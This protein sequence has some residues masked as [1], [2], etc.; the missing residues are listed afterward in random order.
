LFNTLRDWRAERCK[1]DGVPPYV[2]CTNQQLA[3]V[4][5]QRPQSLTGLMRIEGIGKAKAEKYGQEMLA[6]LS[7]RE[8]PP[9]P[10]S[11]SNEPE[12]SDDETTGK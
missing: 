10:G 12:A 7:A 4:V 3:A 2:I 5:A 9:E 11:Q 1:K 6:I 8:E